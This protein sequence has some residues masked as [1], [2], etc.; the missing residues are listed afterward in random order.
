M[1]KLKLKEAKWLV[2]SHPG[3]EPAEGR[4]GIGR[5]LQLVSQPLPDSVLHFLLPTFGRKYLKPS[6]RP[7]LWIYNL[8]LIENLKPGLE[9]VKTPFWT[10]RAGDV[11]TIERLWEC[12]H[13]W[14]RSVPRSPRSPFCSPAIIGLMEAFH[15]TQLTPLV[16]VLKRVK[17]SSPRATGPTYVTD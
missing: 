9:R 3:S 7:C 4:A 11:R 6:P 5:A 14:V 17:N 2:E 1:K 16:S 12:C 15:H 10:F 8:F 13:S